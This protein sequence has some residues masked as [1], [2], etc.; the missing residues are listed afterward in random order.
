MEVHV[1]AALLAG[2]LTFFAPCTMP[3]IPGYLAYLGGVAKEDEPQK[4]KQRII[5]NAYWFTIGFGLVF[6]LFGALTG[7]A[8][9]LLVEHRA[10]LSQIGGA[11]IVVFGLSMLGLFHIPA[12]RPLGDRRPSFIVP[13]TAR[14]SFFM[15]S[16]FALGWSPCLGPVLGSILVLAS[17]SGSALS[18]A[19]LLFVYAIGLAVP[20]LVLAHLFET[21]LARVAR[22]ERYLSAMNILGG[23][24]FVSIGVLLL[25]GKFGLLTAWVTTYFDPTNLDWYYERV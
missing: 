3:L 8:G 22:L 19:L 6:V 16:L 11:I 25:V 1:F 17:T 12:L 24:I 20:L 23:A 18:G 14:G 2:F 13:G 7:A 9:A 4:R 21:S 15:G 10:L 5:R